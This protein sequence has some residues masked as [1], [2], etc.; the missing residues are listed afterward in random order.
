MHGNY[1]VFYDLDPEIE[2]YMLAGYG[3]ETPIFSLSYRRDSFGVSAIP[4][5]RVLDVSSSD[6]ALN[7]HL[8]VDER[9]AQGIEPQDVI[10]CRLNR[11]LTHLTVSS[12]FSGSSL[13]CNPTSSTRRK[14]F[15]G[16][17][18]KCNGKMKQIQALVHGLNGSLA[19]VGS[20]VDVVVAPPTPYL[21]TVQATLGGGCAEVAVQNVFVKGGAFTGETDPD[22]V[23][24][25]GL[26]WAIIGHSERRAIFGESDA[27]V[28]E[29]VA[30]CLSRG[31]SVIAC[32]G[33]TLEEKD[34]GARD[35]VLARQM[36]AIAQAVPYG[37]WTRVVVAYEPVWA[38]GTGRVATPAIAQEVH[39]FLRSWLRSA[40]GAGAV[41]ADSVR[42]IYGGSVKGA[43]CAELASQPD[44]DGFLV[45]GASLKPDEFGVIVR[46]MC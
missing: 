7:F 23:V 16:G 12:S 34:S 25:L 21:T 10:S 9:M 35:S 40:A 18:W 6:D 4:S 17:N 19:G 29:K 15:V 41:V 28:G 31:L 8:A 13:A 5:G 44:V 24:D 37:C 11:L 45:G 20:S 30:A 36:S 3:I 33:E 22:M 38:I 2:P 14:P 27:M 1:T 32:V 39:S 43:N 42:I 26:R 46:S